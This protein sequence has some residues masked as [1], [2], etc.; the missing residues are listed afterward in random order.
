MSE[1]QAQT[2]LVNLKNKMK[3]QK[4]NVIAFAQNP[5]NENVFFPENTQYNLDKLKNS[6]TKFINQNNQHPLSTDAAFLLNEL[7]DINNKV[8]NHNNRISNSMRRGG[9]RRKTNRGRKV[10]KTKVRKTKA[11]KSKKRRK[12]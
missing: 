8:V 4:N 2:L 11:N 5:F 7:Y 9:E 3:E 6:L 12:L 10:R 1:T